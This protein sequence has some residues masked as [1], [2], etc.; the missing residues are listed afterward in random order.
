MSN[1]MTESS[2]ELPQKQNNAGLGGEIAVIAALSVCVYL[3]ASRFDFLEMIFDLSRRHEGFQLD[4]IIPVALFLVLALPWFSV[5]RWKEAVKVEKMLLQRNREIQSTLSEIKQLR[6]IIPICASCKKI[7]TDEGSW[8]QVEQYVQE[9]SDAE[10]SHGL[11]PDCV[12]TFFSDI[13]G[14]GQ[15]KT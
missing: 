9:H 14:N 1:V 6:G 5:R 12:A 15:I 13:P 2:D 4:E 11:C 3:L 10:F 7:R 8:Q